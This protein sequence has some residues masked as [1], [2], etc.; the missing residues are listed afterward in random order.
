MSNFSKSFGLSY[1][2]SSFGGGAPSF[3]SVLGKR[4]LKMK[5]NHNKKLSEVGPNVDRT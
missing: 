1:M 5:S 2:S 4:R 3:P